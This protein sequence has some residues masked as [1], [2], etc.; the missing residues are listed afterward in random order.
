MRVAEAA[1]V[2]N[3]HHNR[4][5]WIGIP[6]M[7]PEDRLA[8]YDLIRRNS[9]FNATFSK[10]L[11]LAEIAGVTPVDAGGRYKRDLSGGEIFEIVEGQAAGQPTPVKDCAR[12]QPLLE[13]FNERL[14]G[15]LLADGYKASEIE[16]IDAEAD[17]EV[18]AVEV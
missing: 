6:E 9:I 1:L 15:L 3:R 11:S 2:S 10:N 12:C 4:L 14:D 16:A 18:E 8:W 7:R 17:E 5:N 13:S